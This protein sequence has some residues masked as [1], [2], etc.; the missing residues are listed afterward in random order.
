MFRIQ[1]QSA[2]FDT[3]T[4][5]VEGTDEVKKKVDGRSPSLTVTFFADMLYAGLIKS[6]DRAIPKNLYGFYFIFLKSVRAHFVQQA[7]IGGRGCNLDGMKRQTSGG[8][9]IVNTNETDTLHT[10]LL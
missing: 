8:I 4:T 10:Q 1:A 3:L 2:V 7:R 5:A 9:R 6:C